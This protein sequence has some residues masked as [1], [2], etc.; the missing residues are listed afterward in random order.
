M[1]PTRA[2]RTAALAKIKNLR[3]SNPRSPVRVDFDS[4]RGFVMVPPGSEWASDP[5]GKILW[6]MLANGLLRCY[7]SAPGGGSKEI[8]VPSSA[9]IEVYRTYFPD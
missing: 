4:G 5:T 7:I 8:S 6:V 1:S 3:P 9:E 2:A